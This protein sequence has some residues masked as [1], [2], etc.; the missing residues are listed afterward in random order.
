[1]L[2]GSMKIGLETSNGVAN[3]L[4][5]DWALRK[6]RIRSFEEKEKSIERVTREDVMEVAKEMFEGDRWCLSL[7]GAFEPKKKEAELRKILKS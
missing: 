2:K 3:V 1:M 7:V 6:G 4:A 5:W